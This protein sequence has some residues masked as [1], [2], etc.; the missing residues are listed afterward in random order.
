VSKPNIE[1]HY[2]SITHQIGWHQ[3]NEDGSMSDSSYVFDWQPLNITTAIHNSGDADA[4][5][6][7]ARLWIDDREHQ[8]IKVHPLV[9]G[10]EQWVEWYHDPL[11]EGTH[12]LKVVCDFKGTVHESDETDNTYTQEFTVLGSD[13]HQTIDFSDEG[14]EIEGDPTEKQWRDAGWT[15][16]YVQLI[17]HDVDEKGVEGAAL[18]GEFT[19]DFRG[20][21]GVTQHI[22]SST[23]GRLSF[24]DIWISKH[25]SVAVTGLVGDAT[26]QG[27]DEYR[28]VT[29]SLSFKV[30]RK[31]WSR[32]LMAS[33]EEEATTKFAAEVS[34]GL[35]FE[36]VSIGVSG[37][38]ERGNSNKSGRSQ[39]W[40]VHGRSLVLGIAQTGLIAAK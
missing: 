28:D 21:A 40:E 24:D 33:S 12:T 26:V 37:S 15:K 8:D 9:A 32:K 19:V 3:Q 10:G 16:A 34:A 38:A 36:I 25:G 30:Q 18:L 4:Q 14:V 39:E 7:R 22:G 11:P 17:L 31:H 2:A 29:T 27:S 23:D 35:D 1:C 13:R 5:A 6:F 20:P